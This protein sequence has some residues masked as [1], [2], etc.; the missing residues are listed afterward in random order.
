M[1]LNVFDLISAAARLASVAGAASEPQ[2]AAGPGP[3]TAKA[4]EAVSSHSQWLTS[5]ALVVIGGSMLVLLHRD[6]VRARTRFGRAFYLLFVGGWAFLALSIW[7]GARAQEVY[8]SYLMVP[9]TIALA[10]RASTPTLATRSICC[11]GV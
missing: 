6:Y 5:L 1:S 10:S 8:L 3:D 7:K 4:F 2:P 9:P 11:N